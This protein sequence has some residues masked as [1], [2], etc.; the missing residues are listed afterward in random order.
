MSD[1]ATLDN[2]AAVQENGES[3]LQSN[4]RR[5][6]TI[7]VIVVIAGAILWFAYDRIVSAGK[8]STDNAY[9][10]ADTAQ[11]TPQV[12]AAVRSVN[13]SDTQAVKA[14][15]VLVTLDDTDARIALATAQADLQRAIRQVEQLGAQGQSLQAQVQASSASAAETR[16]QLLKAQGDVER[17]RVELA[18]RQRLF[19]TGAVAGEEITTAK[20][21]LQTATSELEE[22]EAARNQALAAQRAA[23]ET[24]RSNAV[25]IAGPIGEEPEV[26][27][28]RARVEAARVDLARTI[29]RAP[30]DGVIARRSVQVGQRVQVGTPLMSVV[31][32]QSAY[33]DA[34]FKEVQLDKVVP[35]LPA[36]LT[37]DLYGSKVVYHGRVLGFAGGTGSAFALVPAQNA[38]GNWIKIVQRLPVRIALDPRELH[39]HPLRVGLSMNATIDVSRR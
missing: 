30:I 8:V 35:G 11:V 9:V 10:G 23:V 33:V 19:P 29:I 27:A 3:S 37:S 14:G 4:R 5:W 7:L 13:V 22:A 1:T 25:L 38:T 15:Q 26:A 2:A 12:N 32:V 24:R 36:T 16:A 31:P 20:N 18:R 39:E 17:A 6:L 28:A 21:A 34:N